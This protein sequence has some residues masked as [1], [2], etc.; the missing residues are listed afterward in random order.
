MSDKMRKLMEAMDES[1]KP[2]FL[3]LDKDGDKEEPMSKA[4]KDKKAVKEFRVPTEDMTGGEE[5][6]SEMVEPVGEEVEIMEDDGL[7]LMNQAYVAL[8]TAKD[9]L[10]KASHA[11]NIAGS[12]LDPFIAQIADMADAI[13]ALYFKEQ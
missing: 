3:D 4:A 10:R 12:K 8:G 1:K 6:P 11:R 2:D 5:I 13:E 7:D 9:A